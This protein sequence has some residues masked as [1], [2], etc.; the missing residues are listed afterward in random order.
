MSV[1]AGTLLDS[2]ARDYVFAEVWARSGL[3]R[4]SRLLISVVGAACDSD[5]AA[6]LDDYIR[7]AVDER[8]LT[9]AEL[10]EAA[11]QLAVYGGWARGTTL[12]NAVTRV[13][14]SFGQ[15]LESFALTREQP[16]DPVERIATGAASFTSLM[17]LPAPRP[18]TP[19]FEGGILNFVFGE[20]WGRPGLDIRARRWITLTAVAD[21]GIMLAIRAYLYGALA[22]GDVTAEEMNEFVLQFAVHGGFH[23]AWMLQTVVSEMSE[24][25]GKGLPYQ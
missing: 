10:R 17:K 14:G 7:A 16:W 9:V 3:D 8:E 19:L 18:I 22:S 2:V 21:S 13:T 12:D 20:V 6:L 4:R 24:R 15:P 1:A 23:K 11:L 25:V 5:S